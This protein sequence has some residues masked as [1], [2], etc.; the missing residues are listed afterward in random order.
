MK[1]SWHENFHQNFH[2]MSV[3]DLLSCLIFYFIWVLCRLQATEENFKNQTSKIQKK[4]YW[5]F[6]HWKFHP[7]SPFTTGLWCKIAMNLWARDFLPPL[8]LLLQPFYIS[9]E[10][11]R[12][13]LGEPVPEETFT[14]SHPSWSS[15]IPVQDRCIASIK[16]KLEVVC[17]LSNS[18]FSNIAYD[19]GW[20]TL[21][22]PNQPNFDILCCL[23]YLHSGWT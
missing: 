4:L 22:S 15:I 14:H 16:V 2:G 6:F 20:L 5:F 3:K 19:L 10:F 18:K 21:T 13:N 23:S 12:D 7:I 8:L 17:T 11:V 1:F 9:L